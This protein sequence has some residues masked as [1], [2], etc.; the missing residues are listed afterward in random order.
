MQRRVPAIGGPR[1]GSFRVRKSSISW[2]NDRSPPARP[3]SLLKT[4]LE[5]TLR[6]PHG[7]ARAPYPPSLNALSI[8]A[9]LRCLFRYSFR[10]RLTSNQETRL[11]ASMIRQLR[12]TSRRVIRS[13]L[14]SSDIRKA[15]EGNSPLLAVIHAQGRGPLPRRIKLLT[16]TPPFTIYC[17]E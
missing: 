2:S 8:I 4:A 11:S 14:I 15:S 10:L 5:K 13:F 6:E 3:A 1:C 7:R 17:I 12:R 16:K 9:A